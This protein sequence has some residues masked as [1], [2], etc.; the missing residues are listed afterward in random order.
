MYEAHRVPPFLRVVRILGLLFPLA[1]LALAGFAVVVR[2]SSGQWPLDPYR[3][4]LILVNLNILGLACVSAVANYQTRFRP[5]GIGPF[6]LHS[7]QSRMRFIAVVAALPICSLVLAV[8]I[9]PTA[10]VFVIVFPIGGLGAL[11]ML[12]VMLATTF[13]TNTGR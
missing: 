8:V 13:E 5:P 1:G 11:G 4:P 3:G 6:P 9:P 12:V 10:L 2:F 7:W